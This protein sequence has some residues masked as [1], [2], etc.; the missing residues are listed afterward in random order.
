MKLS[1]LLNRIKTNSAYTDREVTTVTD[2]SSEIVEDCVFVCIKGGRFDGHSAAQKAEM[3]GA[4]AVICERSVGVKNEIVVENTREA[5][6]IL[7]AAYFGNPAEKLHLIGVTGTNGKTTT[8]FIMKSI[9]ERLGEKVGLIGTV[10]NC[11]AGKEY[12]SELTTPDSKDLQKL[13]SDMVYEG[14]KYCIMEV[15]SQALAQGRVKGCRFDAAVFTNLT[16]DHLDYHGNL[17]NYMQAKRKLFEISEKAIINID[18]KAANFMVEGLQCDVTT[19]SVSTDASDYTAK[20]IVHKA[21]GV[22]YELVGKENIGRAIVSIPGGFTVYNSMGA[23]VC[24]SELGFDFHEILEALKECTGVPGRVEVVPTDTDYTVIIDYAH[25]PDGLEN[26][27]KAMRE[28]AT[29][30]IITVFGCGG[31]RDATKRPIMGKIAG[32]LSDVAVVTSDNPRSENPDSIV[33]QVLTGMTDCKAEIIRITDRTE[34]IK[35]ALENARKDD[36]VLLCG[37]GHETYQILSTGKIHYDEREVV[38]SI[39]EG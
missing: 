20:N 32:D 24:L 28:I 6:S 2:K 12:G 7:C 13:F 4:A 27:I 1:Q 39:L 9:L 5:Y 25:S 34:A 3:L 16:Q 21:S 18:D 14:C 26:V 22:Q 37:K 35:Y 15:S 36:I 38:K 30:R 8:T 19:F 10:K 17:Q 23:V 29:A 33:N 31:D 11:V